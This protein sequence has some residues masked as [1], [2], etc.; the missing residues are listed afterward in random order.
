MSSSEIDMNENGAKTHRQIEK[1]KRRE[2]LLAT[3][4]RLFAERGFAAVSL[5]EIGA[6]VG[7]TGQAIYR[8]FQSKQDMLGILIGQASAHLLAGG[9]KFEAE[10]DDPVQRLRALVGLQTD[11]ALSSSDI[12]RVQDRDLASVEDGKQREIRRTQREYIDIWVR[13]MRDVH[14]TESDDQRL[15]RAHALFGLINSTGHSFRGL[16]KRKQTGSFLAY[17][18]KMLP[19]MAM[20]A[21]YA[22]PEE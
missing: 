4:G 16:A 14:P 8:H 3:A 5:D 13:A 1:E 9:L 2:Q 15:I 20:E 18:K 17:L 7:V 22:A 21:I 6:E 12:I 10:Y 11:F 19:Q